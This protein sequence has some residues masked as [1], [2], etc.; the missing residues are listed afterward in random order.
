M[1]ERGSRR[2]KERV[3]DEDRRGDGGMGSMGT[4]VSFDNSII[5][6]QAI[7]FELPAAF[8]HS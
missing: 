7:R 8:L 3:E 1:V 6:S 4:V 5:A 2:I